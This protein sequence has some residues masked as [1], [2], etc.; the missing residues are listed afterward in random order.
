MNKEIQKIEKTDVDVEMI[1]HQLFEVQN[2]LT[3]LATLVARFNK[4]LK[5]FD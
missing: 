2:Q 3:I 4:K 5:F 1:Y